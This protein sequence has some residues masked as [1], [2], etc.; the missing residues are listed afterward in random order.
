[1]GNNR[2]HRKVQQ[3]G[4]N[5]MGLDGEK[6]AAARRASNLTIAKAAEIC[7]ISKPCYI[8]REKNPDMFRMHEIAHLYEALSDTAKPIFREAVSSV[9]AGTH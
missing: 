7:E 9:F 4:R 3:A 2:I 6:I 8:Q 1:M 5:I